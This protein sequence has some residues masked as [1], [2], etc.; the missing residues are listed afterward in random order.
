MTVQWTR[1]GAG[2]QY[3]ADA[4]AKFSI[5]ST[6]DWRPLECLD[7][8][9]YWHEEGGPCLCGEFDLRAMTKDGKVLIYVRTKRPR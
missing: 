9:H 7:D 3:D 8:A 2:A 1:D 4:V 5:P 6:A